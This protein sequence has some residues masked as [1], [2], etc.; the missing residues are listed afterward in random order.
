[1]TKRKDM[2]EVYMK[3]K[4]CCMLSPISC[5]KAASRVDKR[6]RVVYSRKQ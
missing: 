1:M 2:A 4:F 6:K 3:M 5:A